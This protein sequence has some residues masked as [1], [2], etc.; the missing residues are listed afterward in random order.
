MTGKLDGKV[1]LVTGAGSVGPGWGNGKAA[2]A[3]FAR[4]GAKVIAVD[5]NESA[6][7]ETC[8]IIKTEGG[9]C[10]TC[11]ADVTDGDDVKK[12]ADRAVDEFGLAIVTFASQ[13][14]TFGQTRFT[15]P[16]TFGKLTLDQFEG[17]DCLIVLLLQMQCPPFEECQVILRV[18]LIPIRFVNGLQ[19]RIVITV[20]HMLG[21]VIGNL[22]RVRRGRRQHKRA[23]Q[24]KAKGRSHQPHRTIA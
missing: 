14:D 18:L 21:H 3:M 7:A 6:A 22:R 23:Q 15:G 10:I 11:Q 9:T 4:E 2:A 19:G 20:L 17:S 12:M 8:E 16:V 13:C 24:Q 5:I 1:A